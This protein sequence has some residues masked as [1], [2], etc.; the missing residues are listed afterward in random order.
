M[1]LIHEN[2]SRTDDFARFNF[3]GYVE[4]LCAY[5]IQ[6]SLSEVA[7]IRVHTE[8]E[9]LAF[10]VDTAMPCALILNELLTNALKYAFPDGRAGDISVA[11][12]AE[13]GMVTLAV[14][15]TGVGFPADIDIQHTESLGLQLVGM[16]TEQLGGTLTLTRESG[17]LFSITFPYPRDR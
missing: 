14:R 8:I 4:R 12:Q 16:L 7:H 2:L 9:T 3:A 13:A 11:L 6:S 15:D 5:L 17:T 1:A 10:D